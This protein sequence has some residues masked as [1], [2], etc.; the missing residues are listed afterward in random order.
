[1]RKRIAVLWT[2]LSDYLSSCL[3]CLVEEQGYDL[4]VVRVGRSLPQRAH[5]YND[6]IFAW[7]P[8]LH[9]LNVHEPNSKEKLV[10]LLDEFSPETLLV[11]GWSI[12]HYRAASRIAKIHGAH[13]ISGCDNPWRGTLR[14]WIGVAISKPYLHSMFDV[15]WVPGERASIFARHLGFTGQKQMRGLYSCNTLRFG[16]VAEERLLLNS[17]SIRSP[18]FLFVGRFSSE[19]GISDLLRAYASYRQNVSTPWDLWFAG[20]GP[21]EALINSQSEGVKCLGFVQPCHYADVLKLSDA[22]VLPSH[23]DPWPLVIH[24]ATSGAL[25]VICSRQ[26]GSSV[27]LVQDGYNGITFEAGDISGIAAALT[28]MSSSD[29][30]IRT[31][32]RNSYRMSKRYS[33]S[34]WAANLDRHIKQH[35][36]Q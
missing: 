3:K 28:R 19:K 2:E 15:L 10:S 34:L 17:T 9:E 13:V 6:D 25:P 7:I 5:P 27:E 31:Y 1:M 4:L 30:D 36:A 22:L 23:Y 8:L 35:N 11:S 14:Q 20:S 32:G 18:R 33:P 24:E 29:T 12:G 16:H 26:C 21:L